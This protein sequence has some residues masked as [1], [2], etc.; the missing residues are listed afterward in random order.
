MIDINIDATTT[1]STDTTCAVVLNL[2][3]KDGN[4]LFVQPT[5]NT[6]M[7]MTSN[8]CNTPLPLKRTKTNTIMTECPK[9]PNTIRVEKELL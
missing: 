4:L 2:P 1:L 5:G 8:S 6:S 7:S 9:F 3:T